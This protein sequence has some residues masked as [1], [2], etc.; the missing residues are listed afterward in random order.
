MRF[1]AENNSQP[2]AANPSATQIIAVII[3]CV[4]SMRHTATHLVGDC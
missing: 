3:V 4:V 1:T 2:S